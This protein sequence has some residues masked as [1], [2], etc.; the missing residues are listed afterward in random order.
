MSK[1][2]NFFGGGV[3]LRFLFIGA[4]DYEGYYRQSEWFEEVLFL[5]GSTF[6]DCSRVFRNKRHF[7][8]ILNYL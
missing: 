7:L 3:T 4:Y 8:K 6:E 5:E 2:T 1:S